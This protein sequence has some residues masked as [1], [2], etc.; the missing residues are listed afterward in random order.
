M[1]QSEPASY[2][3]AGVS[4]KKA[5]SFL[6]ALLPWVR[7]TESIPTGTYRTLVPN[8]YYASVIDVGLPVALALATD[9][10][11]SKIL[12][13]ELA[14]DYRGVGIDC[15]AM[16]INDLICVGAKPLAMLDY[17]AIEDPPAEVGDQ[18][19]QGLY[20]GA[21]LAGIAIPGGE[22]AQLPEMIRGLK[23]QQGVDLAGAAIGI[24]AKDEIS[25]GQGIE[26]GDVLIG[27]A[28]AG[29]HSN[30]FTLVR[31]VLLKRAQLGLRDTIPELGCTLAEELLRP[32][33]IYVPEIDLLRAAGRLPKAMMHI[34]GGG[35]L[36][37][38]RASSSDVRYVIDRLP[39][40]A[41][42]FALIAE[43]GKVPPEEM[44][45]VF[46]MGV[47]MV[48][49]A[50]PDAAGDLLATLG[51][52]RYAAFELGHVEAGEGKTVTLPSLGLLGRGEA[53]ERR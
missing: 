46:N 33:A 40:P 21:K 30:G 27:I 24:V 35:F 6:G 17:L 44:H 25:D 9:G 18:L 47:G 11:G 45:R 7:K 29:L 2:A 20:E 32:T 28:S 8:G 42:I 12:V 15:I 1:S 48:L 38:L 31:D 13:A 43:L 14:G 19:G 16:N 22:L 41:P 49:V 10:V 3:S 52:G 39:A 26:P 50:S 23:P 36:N 37:L 34:T 5:E 53:F 51:K 4:F